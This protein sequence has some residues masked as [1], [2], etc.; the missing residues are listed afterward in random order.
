MVFMYTEGLYMI[1]NK[2][3]IETLVIACT[4]SEIFAQV[5][6]KGPNWTFLTLQMTFRV[7]PHF[8]G[9]DWFHTKEAT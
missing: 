2:C 9:H 6:Y 7:I 5:D 1:L 4:V 3:F 8:L